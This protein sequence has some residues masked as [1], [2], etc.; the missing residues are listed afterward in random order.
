MDTQKAF[1]A[2]PGPGLVP[3]KIVGRDGVARTYWVRLD[4]IPHPMRE[5][6]VQPEEPP[7]EPAPAPQKP[8]P[9]TLATQYAREGRVPPDEH[10]YSI[11][12][13]VRDQNAK[14]NGPEWYRMAW[15]PGAS[16]W[17]YFGDERMPAFNAYNASTRRV[18]ITGPLPPGTLLVQHHRGRP[19]DSVYLVVGPG[20]GE[21]RAR[22]EE[23]EWRKRADGNLAITLPDGTELLRPDPR[24]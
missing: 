1:H 20:E 23:L 6:I 22:V 12:A 15:R 24:R 4:D 7:P 3:V 18:T 10:T 5:E 14:G 16:S 8:D 11:R 9:L 2:G 17:S 13:A 21:V 19:V